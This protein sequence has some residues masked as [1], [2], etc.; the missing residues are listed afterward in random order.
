MQIYLLRH[1]IA[2]DAKPRQSDADRSL[3]DEG[4]EKLRRILKR[5]SSGGAEPTVIVS[6][7]LR[8]AVQTAEEAAQAL[9]YKGQI[10]LS[11]ALIPEASPAEVWEEIRVHKREP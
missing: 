5:A 7:P 4:R 2:E 10:L 3:T 6:S 1:G 11:R 9:K 8:R